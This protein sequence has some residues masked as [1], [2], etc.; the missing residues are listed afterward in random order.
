M[1]GR[2]LAINIMISVAFVLVGCGGEKQ[3]ATV[4]E[5]YLKV[6]AER[7]VMD[8]PA[9]RVA[10]TREFLDEYPSS[11]Y[12]A[13][14]IAA[15]YWY[16]G[17]ELGDKPGALAYT[18]TIRQKIDDPGVAR[19]VD[20]LLIEFYGDAGKTAKMTA[21]ADRL[22]SAG[23]LD[24]DGHWNVINGAIKA[25]EWKLARDY[26][27]KARTKA[28]AGALRTELS[29]REFSEEEIAEAV[30]QR[31]GML[32]VKKGWARANQGEV[33]EAL[34]DF[35]EADKRVPRYYFDIPEYD[36]Y[37]YWGRT[38]MIKRDFDGAIDRF[39][40]NG[41]VMRNEEALAGL[42]QAYAGKHGS[43]DGYDAYAYALHRKVARTMHDFEMPDYAGNRFR[44]SGIQGD[45]TLVSLWFP[46]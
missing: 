5:A 7:K 34:A 8:T 2:F 24:F 36:L 23:A 33:D 37:V 14:A 29:Y 41:L 25:G 10:I 26:C 31:E 30:N 18:E 45:V 22:E 17:T 9:E 16:Q 32:L 42:K 19:D 27:A 46:T 21:V 40:L 38:L 35:A 6:A 15:I 43:G 12:T 3:G 11:A 20:E 1:I 28:T 39:A 4:E 13:A 44:F